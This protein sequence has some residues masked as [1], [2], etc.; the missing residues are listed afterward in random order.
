M[1]ALKAQLRQEPVKVCRD[2][3]HRWE[4]DLGAAGKPWKWTDVNKAINFGKFKSMKR[5]HAMC[6][7]VLEADLAALSEKEKLYVELKNIL[8]RQP[9]P[10]VAEQLSVYQQNLKE[11]TRQMKAMASQLN[12]YQAQANEFKYEIERLLQELNDAKRKY[13]EQKRREQLAKEMADDDRA[14]GKLQAQQ[15]LQVAQASSTRYTGGGFAIR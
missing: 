2:Y 13:Y 14:L 4:D 5:A 11:K 7:H 12:M 9:G 15:Q 8:A 3:Q 10:E 6:C 1:R